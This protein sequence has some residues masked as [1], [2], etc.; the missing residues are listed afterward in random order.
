MEGIAY[1]NKDVAAKVTGEALVG[2]NLAPFGLS[3]LKIAG[4]LPT[5]LPAVESNEL[6]LDNLFV[7]NDGTVAIIDYESD[8]DRE[9]F[10]KYI[11]YIA[12][13]IKRYAEEKKIKELKKLKMVVIYTADV[14]Q[15][16]EEYDLGGIIIRV[17]SAYL[18]KMDSE[19]IYRKLSG[20][21]AAGEALTEEELLE[22]MILPLTIKGN[23]AKKKLTVR[24][25]EL[26]K[27]IPDRKS[28]L[29]V[30]SGI[31]TFTDKIIDREYS[32]KIKEAMMMTQVERLIYEDG[33]A[34]GREEGKEEGREEGER[35]LLKLLFTMSKKLQYRAI[36]RT[37]EDTEYRESMY[38]KYGI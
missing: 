33:L 20:R 12:R 35:R 11:N 27:Q 31:L 5:N 8:F 22:M 15:A 9:N 16:E 21:L 1:Q 10:V 28:A 34:A 14:E 30:L 23:E 2:K 13:V 38:R 7:L 4:I 18:V 37:I 29:R 32:K 17:E 26:A 19:G 3:H 24:T 6:R 25:I 36:K